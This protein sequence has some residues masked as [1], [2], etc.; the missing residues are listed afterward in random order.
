MKKLLILSVSIMAT[1]ILSSAF[2]TAPKTEHII[3]SN[4]EALLVTDPIGMYCTEGCQGTPD[5]Y[6]CVMC[7]NCDVFFYNKSHGTGGQCLPGE[8]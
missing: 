8:K 1:A 2:V 7:R 5:F 6:I 4:V 3:K